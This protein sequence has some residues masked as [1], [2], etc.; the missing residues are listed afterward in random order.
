MVKLKRELA[1]AK[2]KSIASTPI[3]VK[4][5]KIHRGLWELFKKKYDLSADSKIREFI[6]CDLGLETK[7]YFKRVDKIVKELES[8]LW[9]KIFVLK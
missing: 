8:K 4:T 6:I 7:T 3:M 1:N 2:V 9:I 5:L